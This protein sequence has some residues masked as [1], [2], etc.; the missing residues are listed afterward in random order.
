MTNN[1]NYHKSP[2]G[3]ETHIHDE[4]LFQF[5]SVE[6]SKIEFICD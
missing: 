6:F 4:Q 5:N 2:K 3:N 1:H